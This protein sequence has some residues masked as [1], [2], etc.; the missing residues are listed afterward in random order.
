VKSFFLITGL[1][2][3]TGHVFHPY[4]ALFETEFEADKF[5]NLNK[6]STLAYAK[7]RVFKGKYVIDSL[8]DFE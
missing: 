4:P 8:T 3:S 6:N 1:D 2:L 7:Q 5:I